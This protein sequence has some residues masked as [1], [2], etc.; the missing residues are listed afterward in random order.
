MYALSSAGANAGRLVR[1]DIPAGGV[2]VLAED[3]TYEIPA[4]H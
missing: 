4:G 3:P 1:A 2:E